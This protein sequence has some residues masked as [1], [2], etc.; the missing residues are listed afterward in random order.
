MK[1][2]ITIIAIL[3]SIG[4]YAQDTTM[5]VLKPKLV[6]V[7]I[8]VNDSTTNDFLFKKKEVNAKLQRINQTIIELRAEKEY[9][10][11]IKAKMD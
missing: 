11:E 8:S 1:K 6:L 9:L 2:I 7:E 4:L 10:L 3:F 5:T